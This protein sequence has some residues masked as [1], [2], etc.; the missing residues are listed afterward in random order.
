MSKYIKLSAPVIKIC[1]IFF[2]WRVILI[3]ISLLAIK[4][5]PLGYTDRFLGGGSINYHLAPELFAWANFDGE[6]YLSIAIFGYKGLEQVFFPIYPMLIATA[7]NLFISF[8]ANPFSE[9]LLSSQVYSTIVGLIISNGAFLIALLFLYDLIKIDFPKKISFLV[10]LLLVVFPTSFYFGAVYNES[11]FL[12]LTVLSFLCA[13]R[14]NWFLASIFGMIAAATRIFGVLLFPAFIIEAYLQKK[15]QGIFWI[16]LIPLGLGM[17][18]YYQHITVGDPLAFYHLQDLVGEQRQSQLVIFPQVYYRYIK[19]LST[20]N[21]NQPIY[22]T[23]LLELIAGIVFFILPIY[24]FFKK[25]RL[26][27]LFYALI[28]F[29]ITTVQ[30]SFSSVPRYVLVFFPSFIALALW[31]DL[32]PKALKLIFLLISGFLLVFETTLFLRGYWVG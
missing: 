31:F 6:H 26:S 22:Q 3:L 32:L 20:V 14:G 23:I 18:M 11:L 30:G 8:F 29:L 9:G 24:G 4:F 13:R 25:V 17:Y 5:I 7:T 16:F 15:Y 28:G 1:L 19:M 27:Y 21:L 12:L 2:S 10:I